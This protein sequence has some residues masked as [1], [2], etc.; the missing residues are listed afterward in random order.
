MHAF[1][2]ACH[3]SGDITASVPAQRLSRVLRYLYLSALTDWLADPQKSSGKQFA[4]VLG[5]FIGL[6]LLSSRTGFDPSVV[7]GYTN[8][9]QA[10][11]IAGSVLVACIGQYSAVIFIEYYEI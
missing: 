5:F 10:E 9:L 6:I 11:K 1:S 4:E 2:R 3:I 7:I 8:A